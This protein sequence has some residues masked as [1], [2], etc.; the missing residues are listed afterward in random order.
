M[1]QLRT[2]RRG[3]ASSA[4]VMETISGQG[5]TVG[6]SQSLPLPKSA[7]LSISG[8]LSELDGFIYLVC[9]GSSCLPSPS[10]TLLLCL[11]LLPPE[12][13]TLAVTA[14]PPSLYPWEEPCPAS[15]I[16]YPTSEVGVVFGAQCPGPCNRV[17]F[18]R[19]M[20]TRSVG[21]KDTAG[22][23]SLFAPA[24]SLRAPVAK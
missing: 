24:L 17:E 12:P 13:V 21:G 5:Y 6:V 8:F 11:C 7:L 14:Q 18:P 20:T 19:Y 22:A 1:V 23:T 4:L 10:L 16:K 15:I 2:S 3:N 9:R